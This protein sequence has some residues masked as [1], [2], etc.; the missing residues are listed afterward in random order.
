MIAGHFGVALAAKRLAPRTSLG[1]L[2][3]GAQLVDLLWPICLLL[4]LEHVRIQPGFLPASPFDFLDY[5]WTHSLAM[6]V[7]W[8]ILAGGV[9]FAIRRER[10]GAIVLGALVLSHWLLDLVVHREDLPLWPGGPKVG[11]GVW[12]S[13]PLTLAVEALVFGAGLL[14]YTRAT[15]ARD[16]TGHVA[17]W[18][19][20]AAVVGLFLGA[21]FGPVPTAVIPMAASTLL[22]AL[23]VPLGAWVDRHRT[24]RV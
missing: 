19:F 1:T 5:P 24:A 18:V 7:A 11:L 4:G 16:R 21:L 12:H 2:V 8:A 14:L 20:A 13:V 23:Y 17:L 22:M 9:Y 3:L 6:G 10:A 15:V